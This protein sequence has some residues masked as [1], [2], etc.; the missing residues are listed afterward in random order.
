RGILNTSGIQAITNGANG[1]VLSTVRWANMLSA[2]QS[3]VTADAPPP[4]AVIA[5]PRTVVGF[6]QL[7]DTTQ[8]PLR[9]PPLLENLR[10]IPTSQIP[11]NLT[12]GTSTDCSEAYVGDFSQFGFFMREQ[13]SIAL[14]RERFADTGEIG[15]IAH[16][17]VDVACLYPQAFALVTGIR[18]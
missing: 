7:S 11:V 16:V 10:M 12:V 6:S 4:T 2:Y 17:R 14:L 8:Q 18:P 9:P 1:A 15:F 13:L 5:H 3:I